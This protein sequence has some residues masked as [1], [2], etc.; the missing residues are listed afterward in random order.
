[1]ARSKR[2]ISIPSWL[3]RFLES[4]KMLESSVAIS[5]LR[6]NFEIPDRIELLPN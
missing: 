5:V 4:E 6:L 2:V 3:K 1:M